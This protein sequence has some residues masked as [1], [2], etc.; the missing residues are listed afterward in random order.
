MLPGPVPGLD[1][2]SSAMVTTAR[3][4]LGIL[5]WQ[6]LVIYSH[7]P[8]IQKPKVEVLCR[9]CKRKGIRTIRPYSTWNNRIIESYMYQ[10]PSDIKLFDTV[11]NTQSTVLGAHLH[12]N[13]H[14][15][16]QHSKGI[17]SPPRELILW[18]SA[19]WN[20]KCEYISLLFNNIAATQVD[21][22]GFPEKYDII[23][24]KCNNNSETN[25]A[26]KM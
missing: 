3:E 24:F 6:I 23:F 20:F 5:C 11:L 17:N 26:L 22:D 21:E 25:W 7:H 12:T 13:G 1:S 14:K 19:C 9:R 8:I 16:R 10:P 2:Y 18:D 15:L 4:G